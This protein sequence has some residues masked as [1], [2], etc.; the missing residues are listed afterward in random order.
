MGPEPAEL[1]TNVIL[2]TVN[3]SFL[4]V[5]RVMQGATENSLCVSYL[6]DYT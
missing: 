3:M 5:S 6:A 2:L 4:L 1:E